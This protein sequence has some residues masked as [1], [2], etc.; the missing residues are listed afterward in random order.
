MLKII[1]RVVFSIYQYYQISDQDHPTLQLEVQEL[2]ITEVD[3]VY[4]WGGSYLDNMFTVKGEFATPVKPDIDLNA[5]EGMTMFSFDRSLIM[6]MA[7]LFKE[8][9]LP[10]T[11]NDLQCKLCT[12]KINQNGM[13]GHVAWH[14]LTE[15]LVGHCGYCGRG[16]SCTSVLK[17]AARKMGKQYYK[18]ESNCSYFVQLTKTPK[19]FTRNVRCTNHLMRCRL[20]PQETGMEIQ[21]PAA[22]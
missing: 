13:R 18:V 17:K 7:V 12:K 6:D 3:G 8:V 19:K 20:C 11:A 4:R 22:F 14:I 15:D 10:Q 2:N 21:S 16:C 9:P 1:N 5:P